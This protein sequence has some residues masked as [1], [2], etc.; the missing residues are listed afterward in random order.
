MIILFSVLEW[1]YY[2]ESDTCNLYWNFFDKTEGALKCQ[3]AIPCA[4]HNLH[5]PMLRH[6]LIGNSAKLEQLMFVL[7]HLAAE[8]YLTRTKTDG[9]RFQAIAQKDNAH[10]L[11]CV[12]F[13]E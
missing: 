12:E 5:N 11:K 8:W 4:L 10:C 7:G 9:A 1:I 3:W 13:N 2:S 6:W